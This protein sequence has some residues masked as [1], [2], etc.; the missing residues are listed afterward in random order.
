MLSFTP[1]YIKSLAGANITPLN[2]KK[3][4]PCEMFSSLTRQKVFPKELLPEYWARNMASTVYFAAALKEASRC[5]RDLAFLEIGPH[6]AL[7]SAVIDT[8]SATGSSDITYFRSC[9]RNKPDFESMLESAGD[10]IAAGL[11]I[12][13]KSINRVDNTINFDPVYQTSSVLTD[14]PSYQWNHEVSHW[15][16]TRASWNLRHREFPRHPLLGARM[17]GDNPLNLTWRNKLML[18]EVTWVQELLVR[19][20]VAVQSPD[21]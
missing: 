14:L 5:H 4:S 17:Y 13:R 10:I 2:I 16:E 20:S 18:D 19:C 21:F 6:P 3:D 15:A 11:P 9:C 12:D 1:L 7:K 8:I